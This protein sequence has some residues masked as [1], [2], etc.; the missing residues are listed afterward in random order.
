MATSPLPVRTD[1]DD[2]PPLLWT[3]ARAG[4]DAC[5]SEADVAEASDV[6]SDTS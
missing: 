1:A 5:A 6:D 2:V 4:G 3:D